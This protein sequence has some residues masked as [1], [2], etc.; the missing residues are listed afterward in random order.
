MKTFDD[1]LRR[2]SEIWEYNNMKPE[3]NVHC[4]NENKTTSILS[5]LYI[6]CKTRNHNNLSGWNLNFCQH[7][8]QNSAVLFNNEKKIGKSLLS[9]LIS[10]V[11]IVTKIIIIRSR[12]KY[13]G[14]N[15]VHNL[16]T[17][18]QL[19]SFKSRPA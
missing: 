16:L 10:F 4:R 7:K 6:H 11:C 3:V 19:Q 14:L 9:A 15:A 17:L 18:M 8:M 2:F 5:I 13:L 12:Q 1:I